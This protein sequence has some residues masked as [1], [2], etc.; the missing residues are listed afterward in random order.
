MRTMVL[1]ALMAVFSLVAMFTV[2]PPSATAADDGPYHVAK[3]YPIGGAGSWDYLTVDSQK[4]LL[5]VPRT[6]HTMVIDANTGNT[7]ADITGQKRNHGVAIVPSVNR[8]FISDGND[9]AVVVF[10]LK[11]NEVL[12]KVTVDKDADGIIYD[13]ASK[14]VYVVC[15]TESKMFAISPE[16]DPKAGKPDAEIALG[17]EPEFLASDGKGKLYVNLMNKDQVAVVDTKTMQVVDRWSVAPGGQPV[18]MS[19]D[20]EKRR[21]F[22][23]CR[24]P[25]KLIVMNADDGKV[26]ADLPI[27]VSV[28]ATR[29]DN[30][31]AF[32]SCRDGTLTVAR[33]TAPGKFE[34]IQ[35]VQTK[36]GARTMGLDRRSHTLYLPTA[37]M[38]DAGGGK[39]AAP[40]PNSFMI[41]VVQRNG[42]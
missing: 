14:K 16:V 42:N 18:G 2:R 32:A 11:T 41:I 38:T 30:G 33:E 35:T 8:G 36:P 23:G 15:G 34:V 5:Y 3:T 37:E 17:G 10:D 19:I 25:Q 22:I 29:F 24:K 28:D 13:P 31:D 6:T 9:A 21:L 4:K 20:P 1:A 39:K 12:G 7:V 26:L 27:G 40:K